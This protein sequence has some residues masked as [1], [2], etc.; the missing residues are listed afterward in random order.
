MSNGMPVLENRRAAIRRPTP[1]I[2]TI[3]Q[4]YRKTASL[5]NDAGS[6]RIAR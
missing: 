3:A 5:R 2:G 4:T 6:Y 1:S